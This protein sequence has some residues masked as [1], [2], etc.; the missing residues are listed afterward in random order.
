MKTRS[1]TLLVLAEVAAMSLWFISSATQADQ[2]GELAVSAFRAALLVSGVPA[3][4]VLGA[5]YVAMYGIADRFD[6]RRVFATASLSA[7]AANAVMLLTEPGSTVSILLRIITGFCLAG[8]YPVGMKIM[9][10]WGKADR[11]WLVGLLV[12]GL[13]LG[14]ASPHLLAWLGGTNWRLTTLVASGLA[15]IAA[16]LVSQTSLGPHH[17]A[18]QRMNPR[19]IRV[20]WTDRRLR[21]AFLGY[22]GHMW[23]LYALWSWIAP[24]ALASYMMQMSPATALEWS[25]LTAFLAIGSGALLCPFA[26]RLADALGKA[27]LTILVMTCSGLSALSAAAVFGGSPLL[28]AAVFVVWGLSVIPDSAQFSALIADLAPPEMAGSLMALQTGLGFSLTILTVQLTPLVAM[29]MGWPFLFCLLAAGPLVG[30]LSMWPL[31][32]GKWRR[33]P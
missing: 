9:V 32:R 27:E 25:K 16:V 14:S 1:I 24:A 28:V 22:L 8:V 26:G 15:V 6:P 4:F 19:I 30:I 20:A 7:A 29:K 31:R 33:T 3:G 10:G 12:G 21:R 13:T 17:A 23:E 2:Q 18:Q 11:G 5:L